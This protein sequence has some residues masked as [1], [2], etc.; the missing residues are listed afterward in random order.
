[1]Y[2]LDAN[3]FITAKDNYYPFSS[4]PGVWEWLEEQF[5]NGTVA[6]VE[7]VRDEITTG[8][9]EDELTA[10]ASALP[11]L[12]LLP[13]DTTVESLSRLSEW[14]MNHPQ[15]WGAAKAE[16]LDSAD[17]F[18]IAQAHSLGSTVVTI[19]KSAPDSKRKIFIPE[20]CDQLDVPYIDTFELIRR[21]GAVFDLRA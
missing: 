16:F 14:A 17:Y 19:E 5:R 18:L 15:Y 21:E 1:M 4:F 13:D 7:R 6:T 8:G 9:E 10:W 11:G 2:L 12:D 3:V 20:A